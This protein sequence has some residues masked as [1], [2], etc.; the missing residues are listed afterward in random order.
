MLR[1][2]QPDSCD[3]FTVSEYGGECLSAKGLR[4]IA[5]RT[6]AQVDSADVFVVP[7]GQ[8]TRAESS[9]PAMLAF[10]RKLA[11]GAELSTSVCTGSF[12]LEAARLLDGRRA[13]THWGSIE[14]MRR[15]GT[16]TV[17]DDERFVD[18][19]PVITSAGVSAG[20]DMALHI[21][22]RLWSPETARKVQKAMEYFPA[23]PYAE[24]PTPTLKSRKR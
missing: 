3:V 20:I 8:G 18:E 12:V 10:V 11:A 19:G 4:V 1:A 21:V 24:V 13:T 15:L 7:G 16:V 17:V 14:R 22:G 2:V 5:D 23:P 6:F 9:N